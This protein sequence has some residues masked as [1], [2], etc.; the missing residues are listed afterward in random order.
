MVV[1]LHLLGEHLQPPLLHRQA[2]LQQHCAA[3]L[4]L[5][6]LLQQGGFR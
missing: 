6:L 3:L 1:L 4:P 5:H 2:L